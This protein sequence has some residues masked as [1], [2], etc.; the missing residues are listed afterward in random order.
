MKQERK[1][2]RGQRMHTKCVRERRIELKSYGN[3]PCE[4]HLKENLKVR[5][6][7]NERGIRNIHDIRI[8]IKKR[9][10]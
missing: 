6:K 9:K 1:I 7:E 8:T 5:E 2:E 4:K 3:L 10:I